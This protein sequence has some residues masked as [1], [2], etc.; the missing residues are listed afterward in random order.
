MRFNHVNR[1]FIAAVLALT[2]TTT[3]ANALDSSKSAKSQ[4]SF[5]SPCLNNR[6]RQ[7]EIS[8][9]TVENCDISFSITGP[10]RAFR[11]VKIGWFNE[12]DGETYWD[13][14]FGK[15][16]KLGKGVIRGAFWYWM[17]DDGECYDSKVWDHRILVQ[18]KG[19]AKAISGSFKVLFIA[20]EENC[21]YG[22]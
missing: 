1:I 3:P 18:P 10:D 13:D 6:T 9:G 11:T 7:I 5:F 21:G 4:I 16:D 14:E 8:Q 15:S 2:L 17:E 19:K 20:N 12:E 22:F